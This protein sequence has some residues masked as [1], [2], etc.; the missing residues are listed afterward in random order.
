MSSFT[1]NKKTV[2]KAREIIEIKKELW[3]KAFP[4]IVFNEDGRAKVGSLPSYDENAF[5]QKIRQNTSPLFEECLIEA[6]KELRLKPIALSD[7]QYNQYLAKRLE[8][9]TETGFKQERSLPSILSKASSIWE[10]R[11][12]MYRPLRNIYKP[13]NKAKESISDIERLKEILKDM[14]KGNTYISYDN[15][16]RVF[17]PKDMYISINPLDKLFSS[18][19]ANTNSITKFS[20]CWRNTM[21]V[22]D[23]GNVKLSSTGEYSNPKA[24]VLLG[25]HPLCGMLIIPNENTI[26]VDGMK[27]FGMLQR[28]HIWL[29]GDKIFIEN[30]YPDK[31]NYDR[32]RTI[33][34]ILNNTINVV[35]IDDCGPFYLEN[36]RNFDSRKWVRDYDSA[37]KDG[38]TPYLDRSK[39]DYKD[40]TITLYGRDY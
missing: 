33:F 38:C 14:E 32:L 39:I 1:I 21:E 20:S 34:N 15:L 35:D 2:Q 19:G 22:E 3:N 8:V 12:P 4:D 30:I 16:M 5:Y 10:R 13:I 31:D 23:N 26:E 25:E 36:P 18:G 40:G 9:E 11:M 17:Q 6:Y 37:R 27:F 24:Q 29:H 7:I 28:S